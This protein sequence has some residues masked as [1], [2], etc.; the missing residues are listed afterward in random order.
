MWRENAWNDTGDGRRITVSRVMCDHKGMI[1]LDAVN[2]VLRSEGADRVELKRVDVEGRRVFLACLFE[3]GPRER[4]AFVL[5]FHE[6]II[7]HLPI[8][9]HLRAGL[10]LRAA[11]QEEREGMIPRVSYDADEF[12]GKP[13][14][15]SV[16]LLADGDGKPYGYYVAAERVSGSWQKLPASSEGVS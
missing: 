9:L 4:H 5:E 12:S 13:G 2:S 10:A 15:Y 8:I 7:V 16:A 11:T 14:A 1:G 3:G 6:P